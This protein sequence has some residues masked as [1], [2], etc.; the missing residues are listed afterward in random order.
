MT[1]RRSEQYMRVTSLVSDLVAAYRATLFYPVGHPSRNQFI[2]PLLENINS[3]T[4][5]AG[6]LD[7]R[8]REGAVEVNG[9]AIVTENHAELLLSKE[10]G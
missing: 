9:E 1:V 8:M 6:E 2:E 10:C 7:L 4:A 5:Q 3:Y